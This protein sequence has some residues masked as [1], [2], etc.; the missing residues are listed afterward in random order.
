M[1]AV[2]VLAAA[3]LVGAHRATDLAA[4]LMVMGVSHQPSI[5]KEQCGQHEDLQGQGCSF[6]SHSL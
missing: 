4:A 1:A 6:H 3:E 2:P 5:G